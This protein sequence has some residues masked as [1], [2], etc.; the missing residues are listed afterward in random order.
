MAKK[1]AF[2]K[3]LFS[4]VLLLVGG[5]LV[6]VYSASAAI[7]RESGATWNP[8]L[9]KQAIAAALGLLLMLAVMHLDYRRLKEPWLVY[10]LL[11]G[12]LCL[13]VAVLFAPQ[14]NQT[15]RW[16]FVAGVSVQPSELAKLALV[17]FLAYQLERKTERV[18]REGEPRVTSIGRART[19]VGRAGPVAA[20]DAV[21]QP[22]LLVP[23]LGATALAALLVL[24]EP[25][26]SAALVLTGVACLLL[27]LAGLS[28]R[29]IAIAVGVALPVLALAV[30]LAPYRRQR[31]L[32]F[33]DPESD[34]L[35]S[36]FQV[37]QSLI[38][39]GS[40]GVFGQGLGHGAQK[41]YFLPYPHTD[42][43][44][45][46]LAEELGLVGS[47]V[48]VALFSILAWKGALAGLRA[49]DAF[50]RYLAW[51]FTG[52]LVLQALLHCS[53]AT[54][55]IPSTGVPMP[56]LTYGGSALV[57]AMVASGVVLNV[58]QHG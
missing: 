16:L 17:V 14:L 55:L 2:D 56:F 41:L 26:L 58:S 37:M 28:W 46:I 53:V 47:L 32:T 43:I 48:L 29:Y 34:P 40:G 25:H 15:H 27:F 9:V 45:S 12:S 42:F 20:P 44:F 22:E 1:L 10:L 35:G 7:A 23:T 57:T 13:L 30:W 39:V 4:T 51:G 33:L 38:A 18:H 19:T 8:F 24:L 31:F 50:G 5:G 6:M 36:G 52:M 11:L 21:N 49:P 3:L 54:A